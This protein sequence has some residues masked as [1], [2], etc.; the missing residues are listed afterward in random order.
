MQHSITKTAENQSS[1]R[2][3]SHMTIMRNKSMTVHRY[4]M[5]WVD[6]LAAECSVGT[7]TSEKVEQIHEVVEGL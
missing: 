5:L 3:S 2:Q 6:I 1:P 7:H 4:Y